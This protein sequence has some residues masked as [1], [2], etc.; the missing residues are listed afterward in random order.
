MKIPKQISLRTALIIVAISIIITSGLLY[1]FATTPTTTFTIS[2]GVYPGAPSYTVWKEDNNYFAKDANGMIKYSETNKTE[3]VQNC[4]DALSEGIIEIRG[5][6]ISVYDITLTE[7]VVI[8]EHYNGRTRKFIKFGGNTYALVQEH[9]IL[10]DDRPGIPKWTTRG[11]CSNVYLHDSYLVLAARKD[12]ASGTAGEVNFAG[13]I[14]YGTYQWKA[15]LRYD[16]PTEGTWNIYFGFYEEF[17]SQF[18]ESI[19]IYYNGTDWLFQT[20]GSSTEK[21]VITGVT[22]TN[23]NTLKVDW[24]A[25]YVKFYVNGVLKATHTSVVP[26]TAGIVFLEII[27]SDATTNN[28]YVMTRDWEKLS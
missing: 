21:T 10:G 23:E 18:T 3:I 15:K 27:S 16:P 8:Y 12:I 26:T 19:F 4:I 5:F 14:L 22:W 20:K 17:P 11:A 13:E 6:V 9:F 2:P 28:V 7:T 24:T 1:V 25:T